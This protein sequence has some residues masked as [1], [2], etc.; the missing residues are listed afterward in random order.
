MQSSSQGRGCFLPLGSEAPSR[1][2][3]P[4][5]LTC[6]PPLPQPHPDVKPMAYASTLLQLGMM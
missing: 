1:R 3:Q 6:V 5:C 4:L 2:S